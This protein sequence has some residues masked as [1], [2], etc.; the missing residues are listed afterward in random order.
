M[1]KIL[2]I[3]NLLVIFIANGQT[4]NNCNGAVP[5]CT[6]PS[7]GIQPNNPATNIVDFTTNNNISNPST[8][9][10]GNN[11]GCLLSG[12]TSSTFITIS[13]VSSGT[14]QWTKKIS[15]SGDEPRYPKLKIEN[16][17]LYI[18]FVKSA[19]YSP[20][21]F[22]VP[23]SGNKTG[24]Y[25]LG[26][27]TLTYADDSWSGSTSTYTTG[28]GGGEDFISTSWSNSAVTCKILSLKL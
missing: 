3:L 16:D 26:G 19:N 21:I 18:S 1:K 10:Y 17:I 12:E 5:G 24:T 6:T 11:S 4:P 27:I 8:P 22:A 23:A 28:T 14:L 20:I 13:V 9:P 25:T 7:F 2:L 15:I